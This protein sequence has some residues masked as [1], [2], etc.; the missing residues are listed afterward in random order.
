MCKVGPGDLVN[1]V[2][3]DC[4]EEWPLVLMMRHTSLGDQN[5]T[6]WGGH[7]ILV[8]ISIIIVHDS[9]KCAIID[10]WLGMHVL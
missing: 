6:G 4:T 2:R 9:G 8:D 7:L 1:G 5:D 10:S 3:A